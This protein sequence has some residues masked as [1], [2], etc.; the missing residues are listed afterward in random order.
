MQENGRT[1]SLGQTEVSALRLFFCLL[2][3]AFRD[4]NQKFIKECTLRW[5]ITGY[6]PH[7]SF[8]RPKYN[9]NFPKS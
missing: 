1:A 4:R 6:R 9:T 7:H 8:Y 3:A 5:T 2:I